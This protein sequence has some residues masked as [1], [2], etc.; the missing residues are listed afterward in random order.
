MS[1]PFLRQLTH[2]LFIL[3]AVLAAPVVL[4]A[5]TQNATMPYRLVS[6]IKTAASDEARC[7]FF[8][9]NG[10]MLIGTNSGLKIYDGYTISAMKSTAAAPRLLPNNN[11]MAITEDHEQ[12]LWLGTRNGLVR[13]NLRM[14]ERKIYPALNKVQP[15]A[16]ALFTDRSGRVWMGASDGLYV[17]DKARDTFIRRVVGQT[18]V[19]NPAGKKTKVNIYGVMTIAEDRQGNIYFGTWDRGLFKLDARR[20][21]LYSYPAINSQGSVYT[22]FFDSRQRLWIGT[23]GYGFARM[24]N[25]TNPSAPELNTYNRGGGS[26]DTYYKFVEDPTTRTVWGATRE[27]IT[28]VNFDGSLTPIAHYTQCGSQ[29][30]QPLRFCN[31]MVTDAQG[32][33]WIETLNDGI[34]HISTKPTPF[35]FWNFR[36]AGYTLPVN[37]VVSICM[38]DPQS[39]WCAMKPYGLALVNLRS[40]EAQFNQ[41]IPG[42]ATLSSSFMRTSI[43]SIVKRFNGEV[44]MANNSFGIAAY[45]PGR[46]VRNYRTSNSKFVA[47]DYVIS[48]C[49]ASNRV[50]WVGQ[51]SRL[52]VA[53]PNNNGTMLTMKRGKEDM[54][55]CDV[56]HIMEDSKHRMWVSTDNEGIIRVEGNV[57]K[58]TSLRYHFYCADAGNLPINDA[59]AC[60]EDSYHRIWAVSNSGGLFLYEPGSDRFVSVN[61]RYNIPGDRIFSI[62]EDSRGNLWMTTDN[63]L[64][65][66]TLGPSPQLRTFGEGDGLTDLLFYPNVSLRHGD[67]LFFARQTGLF[68]FSSRDI[69]SNVASKPSKIVVTDIL[70]DEESIYPANGELNQKVSDET[71]LYTRRIVVPADINKVSVAYALL[72][73][74]SP[75]L[76]HYAYKLDGYDNDWHYQNGPL[77]RATYENLPSGTYHLQVKA[78][79]S[80]GHWTTLPYTLEIKILPPWW[81]SWW[82]LALYALVAVAAVVAALRGYGRHI[83]TRNRLQMTVVMTNMAHELLTPLSIISASIDGLRQKAPLYEQ[84]YGLMQGNIAR[85]TRQLRQILEVRKSQAGQLKLQ[86]S[87]TDLAQFVTQEMASFIPLAEQ[88]HCQLHVEV[89]QKQVWAWMDADKVDKMLY[90]LVSN[91]IKYSHEGGNIWVTLKDNKGQAT[92][93]VRDEGI[94]ISKDKRAKMFTRF[95]DGDYRRMGTTGTGIGLALTHDLVKLHHGTIN[96]KSEAGQGT[97]F[98]VTLPIKK[99]DYLPEELNLQALTAEAETD[100][101]VTTGNESATN[102]TTPEHAILIVEDNTDLL[103]L[104]R[105]LLSQRYRVFTAKNGQQAW[106]IIQREE[107]D[108]VVTDVMMPVMDGI[109]LTSTIKQ[110]NDYAQL[111]VIMLTAKTQEEYKDEA[112]KIGADAYITKPIEMSRLQ[113]RIDNML[114]NRERIRRKFSSQTEFEVEEQHYSNPDEVFVQKAID[115][116]KAHLD[117]TEY[118]R[119]SFARDMCVSSSTLYNKLR[120]L[121]GQNIVGFIT[122]IRLK[123]ACKILK[124]QP[125]ILISDLAM[126][127]GF[128]TPKYFS[129]CFSK[130][131]G[132]SVKEYIEKER[133]A[134]TE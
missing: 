116:V 89:P 72:T 21:I 70:L 124:R 122:S 40:G 107:L 108:L 103:G 98:T 32:N 49:Q 46:G 10:L 76:I 69:R 110:S 85:L 54:S 109:E 61:A 117:D 28:V 71:P 115:C 100:N 97:I 36:S 19:V 18:W 47:D 93:T 51:H 78:E 132:M 77:H 88:K 52:S 82:A 55:N 11:V 118:N 92:L 134:E 102:A 101:D 2:L 34:V 22:L 127:V 125:D 48:L 25:P 57:Y 62:C 63:A 64:L 9:H 41:N 106:N 65:R 105:K 81:A 113:L 114:E 30:E 13:M 37:S 67:T 24:D 15:W 111:P 75:S 43:T 20:N 56:R 1:K 16:N 130:E 53:Y 5:Q 112:F 27:G 91:A 99:S 45:Q 33:I 50:M 12:N 129:R 58:P 87:R 74:S 29:G 39:V 121:T 66:L 123:E 23:W 90:N 80:N 6:T 95:L 128:N 104:M 59:T 44:W 26:F 126:R 68:Y 83:Q 94:G 14:G 4:R 42:F 17:F 8:G 133:N 3:G 84:D 120:A 79:D 131:F 38:N 35:K 60:F 7:L 86:A 119:E 96:F 31:D 73:Y